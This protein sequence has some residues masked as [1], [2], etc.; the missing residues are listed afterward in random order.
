[1][2]VIDK[3]YRSTGE[4]SLCLSALLQNIVCFYTRAPSFFTLVSWNYCSSICR[5]WTS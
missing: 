2:R 4:G 5:T 1:V 3:D